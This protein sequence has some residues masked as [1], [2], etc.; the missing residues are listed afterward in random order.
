LRAK[1]KPKSI[2]YYNTITREVKMKRDLYKLLG[3]ES[4]SSP[5][6]IKK[7]YKKLAMQKHPDKVGPEFKE[8]A[9]KE[10]AEISAAYDVL[11]D[12]DKRR[13]Y[14]MT[15]STVEGE[16]PSMDDIGS[17][18]GNMGMGGGIF[19]DI[20]ASV[21]ERANRKAVLTKVVN[22]SISEV[23][24]GVSDMKIKFTLQEKCNKCNGTGAKRPDRDIV[25]CI[26]CNGKGV[27]M[28]VVGPGIIAQST[29]S[30]CMGKGK[31]VKNK[32]DHCH[33]SGL[34][35][36]DRV[37]RVN[38]P[39][40]VDNGAT[41]SVESTP[42]HELVVRFVYDTSPNCWVEGKDVHFKL[43]SINIEE[44]L[45]GF[46]RTIDVY[47]KNVT[48]KSTGYFNP[49]KPKKLPGRGVPPNGDAYIHYVM[50][51]EDDP[52]IAKKASEFKE[53]FEATCSTPK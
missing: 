41:M 40:G 30:S 47:G 34:M 51:Y 29:C 7:A 6:E 10:F 33:G 4:D 19:G 11:C 5:D 1:L 23:V 39:I 27:T 53:V 49:T 8:K 25:T 43:P 22:L 38:V 50:E 2:A 52:N 35:N 3:V 18:F 44:L 21:F 26:T 31:V 37:F 16:G 13:H 46:S 24:K 45:C 9:E 20:F 15:G 32:C 17:M 14:D 36:V 42:E 48:F 12:P 28:C